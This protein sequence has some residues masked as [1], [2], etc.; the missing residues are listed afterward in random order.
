MIKTRKKP[1]P[2]QSVGGINFLAPKTPKGFAKK[3]LDWVKRVTKSE[4]H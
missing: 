1:E 3:F 4:Q 2:I